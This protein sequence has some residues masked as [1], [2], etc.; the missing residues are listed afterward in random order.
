MLAL[1]RERAAAQQPTAAS[2]V[3][4]LNND[5]KCM[6]WKQGDEKQSRGFFWSVYQAVKMSWE[7]HNRGD[8]SHAYRS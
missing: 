4:V 6:Q 2:T 8:G 1:S 7:Q 5:Q 3:L